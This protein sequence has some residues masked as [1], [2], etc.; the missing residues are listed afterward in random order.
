MTRPTRR[1]SEQTIAKST[2]IKGRGGKSGGRAVTALGFT[3]G[4]LRCASQQGTYKARIAPQ[5]LA[6]FKAKTRELT[7]RTCRKSLAQIVKELL[8]FLI[9]WRGYL[10]ACQT[11]WVLRKLT[12]G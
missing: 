4:G 6:R 11:P 2:V 7:R 9:R 10:G 8:A 1:T 3:A 12:T 5:A